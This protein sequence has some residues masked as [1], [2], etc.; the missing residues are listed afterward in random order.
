MI[1][2]QYEQVRGPFVLDERVW[3][4]E[5][6]LNDLCSW[7][8]SNHAGDEQHYSG[9]SLTA[10]NNQSSP[11]RREHA[12]QP[13][14]LTTALGGPQFNPSSTPLSS[15]SLSSPFTQGHS[16]YVASPINA[17]SAPSSSR[18]PTA[19]NVPYNPQDWAPVGVNAAQALYSQSS[20]QH[21]VSSQPRSQTGWSWPCMWCVPL[22]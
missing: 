11:N 9:W 1:S 10:A 16:P 19:Y 5:A 15:T 2:N 12:V 20:N 13:P 22:M 8:G 18:Q 14:L 3:K 21:R 7:R 17:R 6:G 4:V